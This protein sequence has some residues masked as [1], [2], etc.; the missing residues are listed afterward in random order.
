MGIDALASTTTRRVTEGMPR[1]GRPRAATS[2][3]RRT[4]VDDV[5]IACA[6]E[7]QSTEG[8]LLAA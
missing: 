1:A 2:S 7:R 4:S 6:S 8:R 3:R 5:M